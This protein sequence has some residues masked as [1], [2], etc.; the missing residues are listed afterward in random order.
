ME[1]YFSKA[2]FGTLAIFTLVVLALW[3][4]G[5]FESLGKMKSES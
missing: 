4:F 1:D 5:A 2:L 3:Y